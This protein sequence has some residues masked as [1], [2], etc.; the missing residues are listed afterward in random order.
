MH[1]YELFYSYLFSLRH[2]VLTI[3]SKIWKF[4]ICSYHKWSHFFLNSMMQ[5]S[6]R[7][8]L[9][10]Y[11]GVFQCSSKIWVHLQFYSSVQFSSVAQSCPTLCDPMDCSTPGFPAH[12]QLLELTQTH[13]HPGSD[14][15]Q[16]SHP[17]LAPYS[18]AFNLSQHQ[19]LFY[20]ISSSHQ[21]AKL[22]KF[23]L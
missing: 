23:Q 10:A 3:D 6:C 16:P 20:W 18:P 8:R 12:H 9:C 17:L 21:V 19:G 14:D 13:V 22:L 11:M 15:I 4:K 1:L 2:L 7:I 5:S